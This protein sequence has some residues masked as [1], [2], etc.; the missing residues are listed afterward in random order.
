MGNGI[1]IGVATET[2]PG[3][4]RVAITNHRSEVLVGDLDAGAQDRATAD[5]GAINI[6]AEVE[7]TKKDQFGSDKA[8]QKYLDQSGL[9]LEQFRA[10]QARTR[11]KA[12]VKA[13]R[14]A[15]AAAPV[16]DWLA[17][18]ADVMQAARNTEPSP[19]EA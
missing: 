10:R 9:T 12:T 2:A 14:S 19:V 3:E 8:F 5:A 16:D 17:A 1:L 7:K 13:A 6:D 18:E 4:R 15:V 11:A